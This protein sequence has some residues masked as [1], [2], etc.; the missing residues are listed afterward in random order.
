MTLSKE[1][2]K[3]L[4][5]AW[6]EK[7]KKVYILKKRDAKSLFSYLNRQL[8]KTACDHTLTHAQTWLE[9]KYPDE[10]Q[11]EAILREWQEEGGF[12]DCEILLN[13]YERYE[14]DA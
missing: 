8:A 5:N 10:A 12:C 13:C 9:K 6:K 14:L 11:R 1:Q 7:Q 3:A 4:L 2:K